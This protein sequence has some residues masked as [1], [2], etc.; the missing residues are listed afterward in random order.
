MQ[1]GGITD[2]AIFLPAQ[3][4]APAQP[5][6]GQGGFGA[7]LP[8]DSDYARLSGVER[9]TYYHTVLV[10]EATLQLL[11]W[12]GGHRTSRETQGEDEESKLRAK[13]KELSEEKDFTIQVLQL[14]AAK[15]ARAGGSSAGVVRGSATKGTP[16]A[17]TGGT[18][19]RPR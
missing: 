8:L 2:L 7:T 16:K 10:P 19:S 5:S 1:D 3:D 18:R 11:L 6:R 15:L 13:G 12:R 14:R 4:A 9:I 17:L